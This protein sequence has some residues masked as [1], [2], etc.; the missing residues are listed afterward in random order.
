M[1]LFYFRHISNDGVVI[2]YVEGDDEFNPLLIK[3]H[4]TYVYGVVR[5]LRSDPDGTPVY[6]LQFHMKY[7][8]K[9]FGPSLQSPDG[10]RADDSLRKALL[11]KLINADRAVMNAPEFKK[12]M[13]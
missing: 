3:T 6:R 1:G 5:L 13:R 2:F 12:R 8:I 7:G 4:F 11:T 10:F 9:Q